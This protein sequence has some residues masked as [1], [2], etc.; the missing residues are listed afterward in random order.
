[1]KG[2][3]HDERHHFSIRTA[4]ARESVCGDAA[5]AADPGH[6]PDARQQAER[7][8]EVSFSLLPLRKTGPAAGSFLEGIGK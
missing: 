5:A 8:A 7:A 3:H 1:M 4:K 6:S 2:Y